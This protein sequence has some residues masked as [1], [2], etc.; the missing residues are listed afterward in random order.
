MDVLGKLRR[1]LEERGWTDYRLAK[2][3]DYMNPL[4]LISIVGTMFLLL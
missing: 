4:F 2:C 1:L 3:L